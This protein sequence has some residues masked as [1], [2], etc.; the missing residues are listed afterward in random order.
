MH[1]QLFLSNELSTLLIHKFLTYSTLR[2]SMAWIVIV[3]TTQR[4][5]WAKLS[6]PAHMHY[7]LTVARPWLPWQASEAVQ[8]LPSTN[9]LICILLKYE[10]ETTYK[11]QP[12]RIYCFTF[13]NS[14]MIHHLIII[15]RKYLPFN[16]NPYLATIVGEA[17]CC[18]WRFKSNSKAI[19]IPTTNTVPKNTPKVDIYKYIKTAS[20]D[21]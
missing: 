8:H 14:K 19:G 18:L 4:R 3:C 1:T 2:L 10:H 20:I 11:I 7:T 6:N 13:I 21:V 12:E 15:M 9:A 16:R 5:L 17:N